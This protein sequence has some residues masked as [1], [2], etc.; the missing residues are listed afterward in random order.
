MKH[1]I[2]ITLFIFSICKAQVSSFLPLEV[3]NYWQFRVTHFGDLY[4]S[5]DTTFLGYD[6]MKVL[7]DT[8]INSQSYFKVK[9]AGFP[10]SQH[11]H[12]QL[13]RYDSLTNSIKEYS[14]TWPADTEI[15]YIDFNISLWEEYDYKGRAVRC[16]A[17]DTALIFNKYVHRKGYGFGGIPNHGYYYANQLGPVKL[18]YDESYVVPNWYYYNLVYAKV[19]GEEFGEKTTSIEEEVIPL[20]IF[21]LQ[22]YPNPFNP[23]TTI[24]YSLPAGQSV[25][26][27]KVKIYNALGQLIDIL[28]DSNQKPGLYTIKWNAKNVPSGI[29][30]CRIEAGQFRATQKM[31]LV[32]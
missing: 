5:A 18:V 6:S 4:H 10:T 31:L 27:V 12:I 25:Y 23:E 28:V 30:F 1:L 11:D 32:R 17:S 16:F 9:N 8:V 20:T 21:L 24:K 13:L 14:T 2:I 26:N 15:T 29:Y 3:G 19:N 7:K 22:N